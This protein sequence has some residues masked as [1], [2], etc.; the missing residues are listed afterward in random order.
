METN[1]IKIEDG[2]LQIVLNEMVGEQKQ[3]NELI[4]EFI[5]SINNMRDKIS[6]FDEKLSN[7]KVIIPDIDTAPIQRIIE[8]NNWEIKFLI[9]ESLKKVR[10]NNFRL[11]LESD[12]KRWVVMLILGILFLT[13]LFLFC[14][15]LSRR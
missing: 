2:S 8:K 4:Q 14:L 10:E 6:S 1:E 7:Q 9:S 15:H 5:G 11:F 12:A 13:Y 3:G